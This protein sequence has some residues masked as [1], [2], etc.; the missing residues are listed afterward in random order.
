MSC[1]Q[2]KIQIIVDEN[3]IHAARYFF[4]KIIHYV[5]VLVF[6]D[7]QPRITAYPIPQLP[8]NKAFMTSRFTG[9]S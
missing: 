3:D 9:N 1:W 2:P 7:M 8:V 6:K 4:L 5:L